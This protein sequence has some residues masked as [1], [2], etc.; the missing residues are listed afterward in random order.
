MQGVK[1]PDKVMTYIM[2]FCSDRGYYP[3]FVDLHV[4]WILSA[5][6]GYYPH[7][8]DI[9]HILWISWIYPHFFNIISIG[10]I[11]SYLACNGLPVLPVIP[12]FRSFFLIVDIICIGTIMSYL[13]RNVHPIF[14]IY[15]SSV[16]AWCVTSFTVC[17]L[18]YFSFPSSFRLVQ[19]VSEYKLNPV[20][21]IL[22]IF[23]HLS[24]SS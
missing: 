15:S 21:R 10:H 16:N 12:V 19:F 20:I 13:A 6:C 9:I 7:F 8:V 22:W 14:H 24:Y 2:L 18:I 3:H 1:V 4:P 11:T 5:F 17:N 23:P